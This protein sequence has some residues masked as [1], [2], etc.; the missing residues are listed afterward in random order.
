MKQLLR[1]ISRKVRKLAFLLCHFSQPCV[2]KLLLFSFH[3]S[4]VR[5]GDLNF[6]WPVLKARSVTFWGESKIM[7][8]F[9]GSIVEE[10]GSSRWVAGDEYKLVF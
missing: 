1:K 3:I 4:P 2:K 9:W 5:D 6:I 10:K 7:R 8:F